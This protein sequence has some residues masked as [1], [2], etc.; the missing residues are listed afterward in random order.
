MSKYWS[1]WG[2][3]SKKKSKWD[4]YDDYYDYKPYGES[5]YKKSGYSYTPKYTSYS[6]DTWKGWGNYGATYEDVNKELFINSHENYVTPNNSDISCKITFEQDTAKNRDQIKEMSRYFYYRM[7]D[8]KEYINEKYKVGDAETKTSFYENLW[9]KFIPGQTPLEMA[10]ETFREIDRQQRKN[11]QKS[12]E[13]GPKLEKGKKEDGDLEGQASISMEGVNDMMI[14]FNEEAYCDSDVNEL[15]TMQPLADKSKLEILR[16]LSLIQNLGG[17][18]KIEKEIE[19]KIV[20]NSRHIKKKI[21]RDHSQ[22]FSTDL[23][24]RLLPNF[25]VKFLTKDL[26]VNVPIDRTEHKQQIIMLLDYSGSMNDSRKQKWVLTIMIDRLKYVMKEQAEIYFGYFLRK[27][28]EFNYFHLHD[29]ASALAFWKQFSTSPNG[30]TTEAGDVATNIYNDIVKN[31][32]IHNLK[33]D[34]K[35]GDIPEFLILNDGQDRVNCEFPWRTNA[36]SLIDHENDELKKLAIKTKGKYVF[37]PD[38]GDAR[39]YDSV[40]TKV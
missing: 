22:V 34:F 24:Q 31:K 29:R 15:I 10:L 26:T 11:T 21:M 25:N 9:N 6:S 36:I 20:A 30:G 40:N 18:F 5:S 19:E 1:G 39:I 8:E 17:E 13:K 32:K 33:V 3:T 14:E 35:E 12:N 28:G 27:H 2:G 23:Y 37:L 7:L 38:T 4:D 16:N